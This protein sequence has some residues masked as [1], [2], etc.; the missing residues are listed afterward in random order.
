MTAADQAL[1]QNWSFLPNKN[2]PII[3]H[4]VKTQSKLDGTS[5]FNDGEVEVIV[6]YIKKL[7]IT[8]FGQKRLEE[9]D[10]GVISP[11]L[12]QLKKLKEALKAWPQIEMGTAEYFQGREK[13]V[14]LISTVKSMGG[15]GFLSNEKVL[16]F[17][18][19]RFL[20]HFSIF[21]SFEAMQ[22]HADTSQIIRG[23]RWKSK[24]LEEGS[25]LESFC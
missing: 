3:F 1:T 20:D 6:S 7:L 24:H 11:Y 17:V 15:I 16:S 21:Y 14:I 19:P 5:S 10:I 9:I 12:A 2:F 22:R 4:A 18:F 23:R 13:R 25:I 8:K